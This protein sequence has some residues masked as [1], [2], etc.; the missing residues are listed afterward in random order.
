MVYTKVTL[1]TYGLKIPSYAFCLN[2]IICKIIAFYETPDS[3]SMWSNIQTDH[4][5][6]HLVLKLKSHWY[7]KV[8]ILVSCRSYCYKRF[9][10]SFKIF[11]GPKKLS[12][13]LKNYFKKQLNK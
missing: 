1:V 9:K 4:G 2:Q 6:K 7:Y 13:F 11:Y 5:K 3:S 10:I 8:N 12:S